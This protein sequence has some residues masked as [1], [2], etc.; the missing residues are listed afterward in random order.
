M[1]GHGDV[2]ELGVLECFAGF[3]MHAAG[4][5]I[6]VGVVACEQTDLVVDWA[7]EWDGVLDFCFVGPPVGEDGGADGEL[8]DDLCDL[9]CF[10]P[11]LEGA[12]FESKLFGE[13]AEHE[14]FVL[15]VG[16]AMDE[17]FAGEDLGEGFEFE[18]A[19]SIMIECVF[20][21]FGE[22]IAHE[23]FYAH[24]C[25]WVAGCVFVSPV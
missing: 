16:V 7:C 18:V 6:G 2:T 13:S 4:D 25:L 17:A 8:F 3:D 5:I 9:V 1:F 20:A 10:E 14:D 11:V 12:D 15:A 21:C 23:G 22:A 19:P 24:S